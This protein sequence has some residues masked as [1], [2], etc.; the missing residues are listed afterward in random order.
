M[1]RMCKEIVVAYFIVSPH[2]GI[3]KEKDEWVVS[4]G[5]LSFK[6]G[7]RTKYSILRSDIMRRFYH[8]A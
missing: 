4:L 5:K 7:I 6:I 8:A 3:T 2:P 1:K